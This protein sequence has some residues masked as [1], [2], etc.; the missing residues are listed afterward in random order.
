M[1][2]RPPWT[3]ILNTN[4]QTDPDIDIYAPTTLAPMTSTAGIV[5]GRRIRA[6]NVLTAGADSPNGTGLFWRGHMRLDPAGTV[7]GGVDI[8][9]QRTLFGYAFKPGR[10]QYFKVDCW[11]RRKAGKGTKGVGLMWP[12]GGWND[13]GIPYGP[14]TKCQ[15]EFDFWEWFD[16]PAGE[17]AAKAVYGAETPVHWRTGVTGDAQTIMGDHGVDYRN[18]QKVTIESTPTYI[19]LLVNDV[20]STATGTF[21]PAGGGRQTVQWPLTDNRYICIVRQFL[22]FQSALLKGDAATIGDAA[23][24]PAYIDVAEVRIAEWFAGDAPIVNNAPPIP[25]GL[26][27]TDPGATSARVSWNPVT[28]PEGQAVTYVLQRVAVT[29]NTEGG[30]INAGSAIDVTPAAGSPVTTT[31]MTGLVQGTWYAVRV[32]SQ[33]PRGISGRSGWSSWVRFQT[34]TAV[35]TRPV[36]NGT[37]TGLA[38]GS[39]ATISPGQ[40]ITSLGPLT[41]RVTVTST[42]TIGRHTI[43]AGDGSQDAVY[44]AASAPAAGW[45]HTWSRLGEHIVSLTATNTGVVPE[46]SDTVQFTVRIV[47]AGPAV[48]SGPNWQIDLG[49]IQ[50]GPTNL[51]LAQGVAALAPI[52]RATAERGDALAGEVVPKIYVAQDGDEVLEERW[53]AGDDFPRLRRLANGDSYRSDGTFEPRL[54]ITT[55]AAPVVVQPPPVTQTTAAFAA[56]TEQAEANRYARFALPA[57]LTAGTTLLVH[58]VARVSATAVVGCTVNTT[59]TATALATFTIDATANTIGSAPLW[60]ARLHIGTQTLADQLEGQEVVFDYAAA[61]ATVNH[62]TILTGWSASTGVVDSAFLPNAAAYSGTHF[63]PGSVGYVAGDVVTTQ[64]NQLVVAAVG[65]R[66]NDSTERTF[67]NLSGGWAKLAEAHSVSVTANEVHLM[68]GTYLQPT[69]GPVPQFSVGGGGGIA[70]SGSVHV[71]GN[72]AP[73]QATYPTD[74]TSPSSTTFP[75]A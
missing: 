64:P 19:N 18:W 75:G 12:G 39:T 44:T 31:N 17:G 9:G 13:P 28:D 1:P 34:S 11:V 61:G 27:V 52:M 10:Y 6:N 65:G 40:V 26:T 62:A 20:Q 57:S 63:A 35:G 41:A 14:D 58:A 66:A 73:L 37:L 50:R 72:N 3:K 53:V 8:S 49:A 30:A 42:G 48:L 56:K 60:I 54:V 33:D 74:T 21:F 7:V 43:D 24:E 23:F 4:P 5:Q 69:V 45:T 15:H 29:G 46:Q 16:G 2:Y 55:L 71:L 22:G 67:P 51:T 47:D 25:G 68:V 36:A 32:A 70:T 38:G 59:G